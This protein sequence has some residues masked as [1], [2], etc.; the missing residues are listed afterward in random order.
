MGQSIHHPSPEVWASEAG[1]HTD[2]LLR[3]LSKQQGARELRRVRGGK[4]NPNIGTGQVQERHTANWGVT[5]KGKECRT[6]WCT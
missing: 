3:R 6:I 5:E 2:P 4:K 1:C